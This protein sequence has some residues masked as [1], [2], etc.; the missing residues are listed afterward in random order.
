[1]LAPAGVCDKLSRQDVKFGNADGEEIAEIR[2]G[3][4]YTPLRRSP[5]RLCNVQKDG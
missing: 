2:E 1:M 5:I 3:K 4:R